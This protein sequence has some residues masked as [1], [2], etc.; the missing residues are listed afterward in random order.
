VPAAQV[1]HLH[2]ARLGEYARRKFWIG[3]WKALLTRLHPARLV[4]DSHTPQSLKLQM[5]LAALG[6]G[7]APFALLGQWVRPLRGARGPLL[8]VVMVFLATGAR[9]YAMLAQR[10]PGLALA[11]PLLLAVRALALG[12]GYLA[13]SIHWARA[14]PAVRRPA[15]PAWRQAVN[16]AVD[17]AVPTDRAL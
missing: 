1:V 6:L 12:F 5:G 15:V 8:A 13:G 2:D 10:S 14:L 17:S 9:F 7:L 3:Y 4:E 11:G 16:Q